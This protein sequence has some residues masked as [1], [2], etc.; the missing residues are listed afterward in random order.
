MR[1]TPAILLIIFLS[2]VFRAGAQD[3][4]SHRITEMW[5]LSSDMTEEIKV[6]FDTTFSLF[7]HYRLADRHSPL[8]ASPGSYGLP[9]YQ[10]NFFDRISDPDKFLGYYYYPLMYQPERQLFMNTQVPFTELVWTYAGIRNQA[11]QTFRIRHSQP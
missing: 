2:P 9:F 11:E 4:I 1:R 8:N 10:L 7:N 6:P 5:K 3:T